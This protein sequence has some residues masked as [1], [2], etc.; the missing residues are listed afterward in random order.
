MT[1][2][3]YS[4][5]NHSG[6]SDKLG[7]ANEN[8]YEIDYELQRKGEAKK[9]NLYKVILL[10]DDY[11]PMDFVVHILENF[12]GM[13]NDTAVQIMLQVHN[14]GQGICGIFP[15]EIAETKAAQVTEYSRQHQHPLQCRMEKE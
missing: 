11:T 4:N 6:N 12:F 13:N 14:E 5:S 9:P 3:I 1:N 10:N 15:R 8:S 2:K 7:S